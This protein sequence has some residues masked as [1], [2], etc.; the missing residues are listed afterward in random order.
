M[1]IV[2]RTD[3]GSKLTIA[4]MDG[5]LTTLN[6]QSF[7]N[8]VYEEI[9]TIG[10]GVYTSRI[11][12]D[13]ETNDISLENSVESN[14]GI[15][16]KLSFSPTTFETDTIVVGTYENITPTAEGSSGTGLVVTI[17]VID[18]GG[19][20]TI[21]TIT[22]TSL[23]S[24]YAADQILSI[25]TSALGADPST[26]FTTYTLTNADFVKASNSKITLKSNAI[27]IEG[28]GL[29]QSDPATAGQLWVDAAAGYALKVSQG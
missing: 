27:F 26:E 17:E 19:T 1:A 20:P 29:P 22:V 18:D 12:I 6:S 8:G 9:I 21:G 13:S 3:K 10:G 4:E 24:G 23:G 14:G 25:P 5:N 28:S 16:S 7:Q 11:S 15:A 2:T